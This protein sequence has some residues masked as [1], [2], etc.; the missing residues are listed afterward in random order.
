MFKTKQH[1]LETDFYKS[2]IVSF[3]ICF[4]P[5]SNAAVDSI[6]KKLNELLIK[7]LVEFDCILHVWVLM[8][9]HCHLIIEAI[10]ECPNILKAVD[11]FKQESGY[12]FYKDRIDLKWQPSY[13]DHIVRNDKDLMNQVYYIL[14]DKRNNTWFCYCHH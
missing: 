7:I 11:R 4:L 12:W 10:D 9:D 3:T 14:N 1:R 6:F 8:P 13:Y 2:Q 5:N